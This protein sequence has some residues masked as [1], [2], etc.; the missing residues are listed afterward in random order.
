M[1]MG[2]LR[3][4]L[5]FL[6][7]VVAGGHAGAAQDP[8]SPTAMDSLMRNVASFSPSTG[9]PCAELVAAFRQADTS[10]IRDALAV[11]EAIEDRERPGDEALK[12]QFARY[13]DRL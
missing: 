1:S 3:T 4:I 13:D 11:A 6:C 7:V 5:A 9:S 8:L 12:V 10:L 2:A